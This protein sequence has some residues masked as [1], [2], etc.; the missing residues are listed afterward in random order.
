MNM[1]FEIKFNNS[2]INNQRNKINIYEDDL[3]EVFDSRT[4]CLFE[5]IE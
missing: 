1:N 3:N 2:L 4:F 5:Y